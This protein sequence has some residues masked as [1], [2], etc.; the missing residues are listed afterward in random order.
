MRTLLAVV[1]GAVV[2]IPWPAS[3]LPA[4][5]GAEGFGARASG[6]R[7]GQV[8]KVTT[9]AASG[10]G[11]LQWAL[12]QPGPRTIV[13]AVSG[14]ITGDVEI[15]HGDV[16]VAG[17]SAPGA[18]ITIQGHLT[19]PYG[20]SFGNI[21]IRHL[22]VRPPDPDGAWPADQHDAVQLSTVHTVILDHLDLSNAADE[23][24][25]LGGGASTVTV[26]YSAFTFPI[27][28]PGNGWT[29]NQ[30][31]INHRPCLDD[32]SCG[33]G[34]LPG[35]FISVHHNLFVHARNRTPALSVGPAEL[36]HNVVY[37]GREGFVHH[38]VAEGDFNLVG[39]WYVA[40]PS[41]AL[42]PFWFDP[43][44]STT[45]IPTR[46][47]LWDNRVEDPGV[48]VGRVDDPFTTPGF[49]VYGIACCGL[50]PSQFNAWGELDL[51]AGDSAYVPVTGGTPEQAFNR[52][53]TKAGAWPR[54]VVTRTAVAHVEL[55]SGAWDNFRPADLLDGLTPTAPPLD[56]DD[57]GMADAWE[58]EAGLDPDDPDDHATVMPSGYTA[59]EVY[60][61]H[62]ARR[63]V[64][65]FVDGVESGDPLAWSMASE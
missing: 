37:N 28:D 23:L 18:G 36:R 43:E 9:L 16:T 2:A 10:V 30:G 12:D 14:V 46:Y 56:G 19:T 27:Y 54:D 34:S 24:L 3:A 26:Q 31:M 29:H 61:D 25:D 4:F 6:G 48:F 35:G 7:G 17:Q 64:P 63:M 44:N 60:L 22:R 65:V 15:P 5:P 32:A 40:G 20:A 49:D 57:D 55:R 41:I 1:L 53:L 8:V 52:V 33:P 58:D 21:V 47:W 11:S 59:I 39:N 62:L 38:N 50:E 45:P 13:F 51:A 42:A